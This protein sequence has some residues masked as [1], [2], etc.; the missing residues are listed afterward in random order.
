ML[1]K[2]LGYDICNGVYDVVIHAGAV[3]ESQCTNVRIFN[4]NYAWVTW[5]ATQVKISRDTHVL[6]FSTCMVKDPTNLYAWTKLCAEDYLKRSVLPRTTI[7]RPFNVFGGNESAARRSLPRLLVN[8]EARNIFKGYV[9]DYIHVDDVCR[10]VLR[11]LDR[12][13]WGE[14]FD[15]GTTNG[16]GALLLYELAKEKNPF[17]NVCDADDVLNF[18]SPSQLVADHESL[19]PGFQADRNVLDWIREKV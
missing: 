18:C 5:L 13:Y 14:S 2:S 12:G 15:I 10:G 17:V 16:V 4:F 11:I 19:P 1:E 9:R 6:F 7:I 8:G 3:S